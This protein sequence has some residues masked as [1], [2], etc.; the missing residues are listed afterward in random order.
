MVVRPKNGSTGDRG[1]TDGPTRSSGLRWSEF[2]DDNVMWVGKRFRDTSDSGEGR[3]I[4]GW[5][6]SK[7]SPI[8]FSNFFSKILFRKYFRII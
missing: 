6:V 5:G 3:D 1:P 7:R 8:F 4:W 2:G